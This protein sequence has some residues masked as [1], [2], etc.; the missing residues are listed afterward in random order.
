M[1]TDAVRKAAEAVLDATPHAETCELRLDL[2]P[3]TNLCSCDHITRAMI[4]FA[5]LDSRAGDAG[6]ELDDIAVIDF[7]GQ[8]FDPFDTSPGAN[9]RKWIRAV[10][11]AFQATRKSVDHSKS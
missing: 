11:G 8:F 9:I 2:G 5:A 6:H 1:M 10:R 3:R 7:A 4:A